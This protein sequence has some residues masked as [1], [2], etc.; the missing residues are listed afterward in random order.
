MRLPLERREI[1][2]PFRTGGHEDK[3]LLR[4]NPYPHCRQG[5][6]RVDLL[7]G[8]DVVPGALDGQVDILRETDPHAEVDLRPVPPDAWRRVEG[9][10]AFERIVEI[11]PANRRL[12]ALQQRLASDGWSERPVE[13]VSNLALRSLAVQ[14]R[15]R[16]TGELNRGSQ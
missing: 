11:A 12:D 8:A 14:P 15:H 6:V 3:F 10:I 2:L 16:L 7:R 4:L 1:L 9:G 13:P 5:F